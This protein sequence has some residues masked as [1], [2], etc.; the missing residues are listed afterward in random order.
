LRAIK[1]SGQP[2][3]SHGYKGSSFLG[4]AF[5]TSGPEETLQEKPTSIKYTMLESA[6]NIWVAGGAVKLIFQKKILDHW[7][8]EKDRLRPIFNVIKTVF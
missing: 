8:K 2:L 4:A 7:G 3:D 6:N 5:F 1:N